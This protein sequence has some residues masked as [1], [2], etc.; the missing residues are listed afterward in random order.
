MFI[1]TTHFHQ[2]IGTY[3]LKDKTE[4][5]G[6]MRDAEV[7]TYERTS[8]QETFTNQLVISFSDFSS[9]VVKIRLFPFSSMRVC[10]K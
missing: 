2:K 3:F 10:L 7:A 5:I 8:M 4:W 1:L 6:M 9:L